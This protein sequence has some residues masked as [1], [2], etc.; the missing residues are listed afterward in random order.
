[1][2]PETAPRD[3]HPVQ[4][5]LAYEEPSAII[6]GQAKITLVASCYLVC[7]HDIQVDHSRRATSALLTGQ[8]P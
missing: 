5:S 6:G 2:L 3:S 7:E 1:V 4:V 8:L